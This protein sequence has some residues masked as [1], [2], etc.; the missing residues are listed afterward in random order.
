MLS[1]GQS[2]NGPDGGLYLVDFYRGIIQHK[3]YMTPFLKPVLDRDSMCRSTWAEFIALSP[4][5]T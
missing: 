3:A 5:T 1:A 4:T 2:P